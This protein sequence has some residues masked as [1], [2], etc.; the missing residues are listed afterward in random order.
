ML[1]DNI[2]HMFP[3]GNTPL[4]FYSYYSHVI[5][6]NIANKIF[7]L[8]GAP[9]TGKSSIMK[10]IAYEMLSKGYHVEFMHCPSD[11]DSLDGVVIPNLLVAII[12]GTPPHITD[13]IY[14]GVVDEIVDLGQFLD[15]DGVMQYKD[16]II[17]ASQREKTCFNRAFKYLNAASFLIEDTRNIYKTALNAG[18][19]QMFIQELKDKLFGKRKI[20]KIAGKQRRLFASAFTPKGYVDYLDSLCVNNTIIRLNL[21]SGMSTANIMKSLN[22]EAIIKGIDI[23]TYYCPMSP[24]RIEHIVIPELNVSIITANEYHD[25]KAINDGDCINYSMNEFYS[26]QII[27]E[28][29]NQLSFNRLYAD[30]IIQKAVESIALAKSHH[31]EIEK[32]YV[33]NMDFEGLSIQKDILL[34]TIKKY[35]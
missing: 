4:G 32:Y 16:K 19:K 34:R 30:T 23:E 17:L 12:D 13:P 27:Q 3:A 18:A 31:N 6:E 21:S 28:N 29:Q 1:E 2:R 20:S 33:Q 5:D 7:I 10:N 14:P 26:E 9:G 25:V 22:D 35:S 15:L 24:Q 8:K 11:N